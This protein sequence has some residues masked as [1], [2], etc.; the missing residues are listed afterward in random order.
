MRSFSECPVCDRKLKG[1]ATAC[2]CGWAAPGATKALPRDSHHG[3]CAWHSTSGQ[4]C[5]F[6]APFSHGQHGQG[7]WY[8]AWHFRGG[9]PRFMDAVV[10]Q[11]H[12]WDGKPE[13]YAAMRKTLHDRQQG[14]K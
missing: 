4:L 14:A 7:P 9:D 8:C 6:P 13:T 11:S 5:Q 1:G 10:D 12:A 2:P 3:K